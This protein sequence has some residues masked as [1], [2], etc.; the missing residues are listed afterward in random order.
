MLYLVTAN[1]TSTGPILLQ[2]IPHCYN[3]SRYRQYYTNMN[4]LI[5]ANYIT[6]LHLGTAITTLLYSISLQPIPNCYDLS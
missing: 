2:P 3:L 4:Y 5:T 6:V 1:T